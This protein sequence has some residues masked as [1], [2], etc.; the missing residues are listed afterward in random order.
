VRRSVLLPLTVPSHRTPGANLRQILNMPAS[1][2]DMIS[3]RGIGKTYASPAGAFQAL[4]AIDLT[5]GRGEF[6]AVVG[7]SGSGKSTLLNLLGGID[8]PSS[9][10]IHIDGKALHTLPEKALP[11]WRGR[12][13]GIV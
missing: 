10:E 7:Q 12:T 11:A 8:R 13:V 2:S 4:A 3:L 5:I 9:G 1:S 6:V